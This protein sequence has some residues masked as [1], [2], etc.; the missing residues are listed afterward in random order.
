[1]DTIFQQVL[2]HK[3]LQITYKH[4]QRFSTLLVLRKLQNKTT[5]INWL[6]VM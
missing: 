5:V 2:Q 1:M 3:E 4:M 6:Y